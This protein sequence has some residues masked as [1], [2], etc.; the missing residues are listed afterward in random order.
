M[1]PVTCC[2]VV[3]VT[4]V[5]TL[6]PGNRAGASR[7]LFFVHSVPLQDIQHSPR[8]ESFPSTDRHRLDIHELPDA[9]ARQFPAEAGL[10]NAAKRQT[11]IGLHI[12]VHEAI[13]RLK[14]LRRNLL[15]MWD[16][17]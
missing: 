17:S 2:S 14:A 15:P 5:L 3:L 9:K 12:H 11:R 1:G 6:S 7:L 10:L 8:A 4:A 16:V 13:A